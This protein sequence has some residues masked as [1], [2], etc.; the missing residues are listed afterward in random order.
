MLLDLGF[1]I[2][3]R[4]SQLMPLQETEFLG[5]LVNSKTMTFSVPQRKISEIQQEAQELMGQYKASVRKLAS[6]LGKTVAV[7]I[8]T[9]YQRLFTRALLRL[10]NDAWRK[11]SE[12][13]YQTSIDA[14]TK[15]ELNW[16]TSRLPYN[17]TAPIHQPHP[18]TSSLAMHQKRDGEVG[19]AKATTTA[20]KKLKA[21]GQCKKQHSTSM[22]RSY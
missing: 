1:T 5:I 12:W 22:P 10:K 3:A 7:S 20:S 4:K 16:W 17:S 18:I 14:K 13:S 8:A 15:A 19:P 21:S 6:F 2:N 9:P 11:S